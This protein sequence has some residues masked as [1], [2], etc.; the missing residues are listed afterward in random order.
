MGAKCQP[1]VKS[2]CLAKNLVFFDECTMFANLEG[3][4][5]PVLEE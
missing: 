3:N 1:D 2:M 4:V 5:L